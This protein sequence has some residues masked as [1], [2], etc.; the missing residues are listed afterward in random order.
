M[1]IITIGN[2]IIETVEIQK[3]LNNPNEFE[4]W[5]KTNNEIILDWPEVKT[6]HNDERSCI[7]YGEANGLVDFYLIE[8]NDPTH[9]H[10]S[11]RASIINLYIPKEKQCSEIV[12][13]GIAGAATLNKIEEILNK[14]FPNQYIVKRDE[15]EKFEIHYVIIKKQ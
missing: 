10:W 12:I 11:S 1:E 15:S 13:N 5:I 6:I 9:Y 14:F 2:T 7:Y 4:L 3:D 8:N